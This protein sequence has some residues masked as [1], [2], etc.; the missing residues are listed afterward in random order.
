M[1]YN[2]TPESGADGPTSIATPLGLWAL[3]E[4]GRR[5]SASR[6]RAVFMCCYARV[7]FVD[8]LQSF[9]GHR[10]VCCLIAGCDIRA[11]RQISSS[12]SPLR[13]LTPGRKYA[14]HPLR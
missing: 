2:D 9:M 4:G 5:D 12:Q 14:L 13:G 11:K 6:W 7:K 1:R 10:N 8:S 3:P